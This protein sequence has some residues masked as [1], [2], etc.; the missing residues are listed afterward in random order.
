MPSRFLSRHPADPDVASIA[1]LIGNRTRAAILFALLDGG[2]LS[3]SELAFR[4]GTSPTATST[5]LAKLV[6]AQ[7]LTARVSGRQRLFALASP[8]IAHAMEALSVIAR[9][10]PIVGLSQNTSVA[11]IREAR[12]CYDHLAGRLGVAFTDVLLQRKAL[13]LSEKEFIVT[14]SGEAFFAAVEVDVAAA[15]EKRRNFARA[16]T[17]WTERRPHLA[18]SLGAAVLGRFLAAGWVTRHKLD[19][20]LSITPHGRIELQERF[21]IRL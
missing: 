10:R 16:C 14:R 12:S 1:A 17:D 11:R 13:R 18:G 19:R 3:A 15:R 8:D 7:L 5:H 9:P 4:A 21:G 6:A 20:S 2:E